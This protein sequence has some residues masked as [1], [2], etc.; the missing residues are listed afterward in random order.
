MLPLAINKSV[1]LVCSE[2]KPLLHAR[3]PICI[4][5]PEME[6]GTQHSYVAAQA[7]G[8]CLFMA[9]FFFFFSKPVFFFFLWENASFQTGA[10]SGYLFTSP[11]ELLMS[12]VQF[13]VLP[14][15]AEF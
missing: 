13:P 4:P 8:R 9:W 1:Q 2:T 10:E 14:V 11:P 6:L 3:H 15:K 7:A 12:S 5:V